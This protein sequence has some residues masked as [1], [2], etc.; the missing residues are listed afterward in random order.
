MIDGGIREDIEIEKLNI[1]KENTFEDQ[2]NRHIEQTQLDIQPYT[3]PEP[4]DKSNHTTL[5]IKSTTFSGST[6]TISFYDYKKA[7]ELSN[8]DR[9]SKNREQDYEKYIKHRKN[10]PLQLSEIQ[11]KTIEEYEDHRKDIEQQRNMNMDT[12]GYQIQT[13]YENTNKQFLED[14]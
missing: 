13:H 8:I 1:T 7:F 11:K 12:Y 14:A 3:V 9:T 2:F 5:G 10:D 4:I 6:N